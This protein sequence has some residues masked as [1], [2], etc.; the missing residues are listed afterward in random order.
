ML[1]F[2]LIRLRSPLV[3]HSKNA[4]CREQWAPFIFNKCSFNVTQ[5]SIVLRTN[6]VSTMPR[7]TNFELCAFFSITCFKKLQELCLQQSKISSSSIGRT[8]L[9]NIVV[10]LAPYYL[11]TISWAVSKQNKDIIYAHPNKN[12]FFSVIGTISYTLI[13]LHFTLR[14]IWQ[15]V[16]K[17]LSLRCCLTIT[18]KKPV[19]SD[20]YAAISTPTKLNSNIV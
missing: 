7:E 14:R 18:K 12:W 11:Q 10:L 17:K 15:K 19:L 5:R 4:Y 9:M 20:K 1:T 3:L 16:T 8:N 2:A 13:Q 6:L